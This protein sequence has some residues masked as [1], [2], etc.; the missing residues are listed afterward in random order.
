[1]LMGAL[2]LIVPLEFDLRSQ[3]QCDWLKFTTI[4]INP[5]A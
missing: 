3:L 4:K 1:M 2:L 5:A